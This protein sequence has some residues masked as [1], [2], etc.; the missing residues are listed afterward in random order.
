MHLLKGTIVALV[1]AIT[2]LAVCIPLYLFGLVRLVVRP[3]SFRRRLAQPMDRVIDVWVSVF[4]QLIHRFHLIKI[5]L[6]MPVEIHD[7]NRWRVIL[8]NHQSW[9]DII[10]LQS[11]FRDVAPVL[12]FF[13]KRELIWVPLVGIAMWILGFPYVYRSRSH[14]DHMT[15]AQRES[16]EAV[17]RREGKRFLEKP[18]AVINFVEGTRFSAE[19]RDSRDSPYE[20]LLAPR[21]GGILRSL[22]VLGDHVTS[23]LDV[24]IVYSGEVPGFWDLLTGRADRARMIVREVDRPL[25]EEDALSAWLDTRWREKDEILRNK[26]PKPYQ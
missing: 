17:M 15:A 19:K 11:S 9:V 5:D 25:L 4:R 2:T 13:T 24:T 6:D 22:L 20:N 7:R 14:S 18:V 1:V 23:V 21:R 3:Q 10:L 26:H 8:C 16:N 12:K